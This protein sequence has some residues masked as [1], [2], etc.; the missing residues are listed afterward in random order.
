ME[1]NVVRKENCERGRSYISANGGRPT[2][3]DTYPE[4][5]TTKIYQ[6][7]ERQ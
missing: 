5:E 6:I 2:S 1:T 7:L 3:R 4:E